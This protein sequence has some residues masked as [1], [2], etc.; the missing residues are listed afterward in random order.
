M[1]RRS[2]VPRA[3]SAVPR[4][5]WVNDGR[6]CLADH[7]ILRIGPSRTTDGADN[8]ALLDQWNATPRRN[9]SVEGEQI[10][11]MHKLDPILEDLCFAPE[12][13][14]GSRLVLGNR[15]G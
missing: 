5:E 4:R 14:G 3:G 12:G 11:E 15:N 6:A 10:V 13:R 8:L 7:L 9:D 2:A 1:R